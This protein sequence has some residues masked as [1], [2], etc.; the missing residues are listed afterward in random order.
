MF[1]CAS[2]S[3]SRLILWGLIVCGSIQKRCQWYKFF[4]ISFFETRN[5][6]M[7]Q[8]IYPLYTMVLL[9]FLICCHCQNWL[10]RS[11]YSLHAVSLFL[12]ALKLNFAVNG[13]YYWLTRSFRCRQDCYPSNHDKTK[14]SKEH[15]S[16][17]CNALHYF[18]LFELGYYGSRMSYGWA[19]DTS[20]RYAL[21]VD[22]S[23]VGK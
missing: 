15:F 3:Y 16:P 19:M 14:P 5:A 13:L 1:I 21:F 23:W 9:F 7:P 22:F 20:C 10:S 18:N 11:H 2:L 8:N 12:S 6:K 17:C 4:D